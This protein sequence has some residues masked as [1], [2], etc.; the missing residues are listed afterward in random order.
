M[1]V[2]VVAKLN[3][4]FLKSQ[5]TNRN[6]TADQRESYRA[7]YVEALKEYLIT[8]DKMKDL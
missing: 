4:I 3:L 8:I 1:K 2:K 7:K 6:H 5:W